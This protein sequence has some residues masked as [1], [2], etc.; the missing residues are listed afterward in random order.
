MTNFRLLPD[1]PVAADKEED[2]KFGHQDIAETVFDII[3]KAEP[4]FT[5]GLY[6]R[7]GV[8]K[9]TIAGLVE[10][11]AAA[12]DIATFFFDVW[13]YERDSLRRQF[14]IELDKKLGLGLRFKEVLNQSLEIEDPTKASIVFD[15]RLLGNKMGYTFLVVFGVG[16]FAKI[17]GIVAGISDLATLFSDLFISL[18][19]AG[20][21]FQAGAS[22]ITRV[23]QVV[24]KY[25]TDSAEGFEDRFKEALQKVKEKKILIIID[26]LDRI[27]DKKMLEVLSDVKTFLSKDGEKQDKV[28][29]L[30]PCDH[31]ALRAQLLRS[32]EE[33]F[34]VDEFLRKFFNLTF[35]IPKFISLDLNEYVQALIKET[36]VD[37]FLNDRDL[38]SVIIYAF[39][40]NPREIKQFINSLIA[41]FS[42]AKRRKLSIV[43]KNPAFLAKLLVIKQKF[44]PVYSTLS[45]KALRKN[46]S[47]TSINLDNVARE[48]LDEDLMIRRFEEFNRVTEGIHDHQIVTFLTLRQSDLEK[49]VPDSEKLIL[50]FEEGRK[51]DACTIAKDIISTG[52]KAQLDEILRDWVARNHDDGQTFNNFVV[53]GLNTFADLKEP[54]PK[55]FDE[56]AGSFPGLPPLMIEQLKPETFVEFFIKNVSRARQGSLKRRYVNFV[57]S[58]QNNNQPTFTE[59]YGKSHLS[60]LLRNESEF[61]GEVEAIKNLI[62]S[63]MFWFPYISLFNTPERQRKYISDE[64]QRRFVSSIDPILS[65]RPKGEVADILNFLTT[66]KLSSASKREALAKIASFLDE[67]LKAETPHHLDLL[68]GIRVFLE[69]QEFSD[70]S[71]DDQKRFWEYFSTKLAQLF[72]S[73]KDDAVKKRYEKQDEYYP[74]FREL[75]GYDINPAKHVLTK[76]ISTLIEQAPPEYIENKKDDFIGEVVKLVPQALVGKAVERPDIFIKKGIFPMLPTAQ[77]NKILHR[78]TE[79]SSRDLPKALSSLAYAVQDPNDQINRMLPKLKEVNSESLLDW[80]NSMKKMDIGSNVTLIELLFQTL[81]GV[82][83]QDEQRD[84]IVK[85]FVSAN[86]KIFNQAQQK[87]LGVES[88]LGK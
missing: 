48:K 35:E 87:A 47:F 53:T 76:K 67:E 2:I 23:H 1:C 74:I 65:P 21:L 64:A 7:W 79:K 32:Y 15:W 52:A 18:G 19:L 24:T 70:L 3:E 14:L 75:M 40:D 66:L 27:E 13:K 29:F 20:F 58:H 8:G 71:Q 33:K 6:G 81:K 5:I 82:R 85:S 69:T 11:K 38:E 78:I 17:Y 26:N 25:R 57:N 4:P 44:Y 49:K 83:N 42:L 61:T 55:F 34:D 50:A 10:K 63:H 56:T 41:A 73:E 30:I 37:E 12:K 31:T 54:M 43:L 59:D 9:T 84:K 88:D 62:Q 77:S 68:R 36:G 60:T 86:K 80:L 28:V 46:I 51:D 16:L 72:E 22:A 39:R 45:E